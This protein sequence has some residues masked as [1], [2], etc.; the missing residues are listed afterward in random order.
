MR[1]RLVTLVVV[2]VLVGGLLAPTAAAGAVGGADTPTFGQE[3]PDAPDDDAGDETTDSTPEETDAP[4]TAE[5][6]R[7][8]PHDFGEEF[9]SAET[10]ESDKEFNTTGPFALFTTSDPVDAARIEQSAASAT[11]LDGDQAVLV[12][13]DAEAAG[14][15]EQTFFALELF[16]EDGSDT[17][18]DVY[19]SETDVSVEAAELSEFSGLIDQM[20]TDAEAEGYESDVG[21]VESYYEWQNDRVEV[22]EN[23]LVEHA[24]GLF[25]LAIIAAMN[26]LAWVLGLGTI[27]VLAYRR[28]SALGWMLDRIENDAGETARKEREL[29]SRFENQIISADEEPLTELDAVGPQQAAHWKDTYSV[30]SVR[31]LAEL[32]RRG[33]RVRADGGELADSHSGVSEIN[34]DE[35]DDSWLEAIY[36]TNRLSGPREALSHV[37]AALIRMDSK[38]GMG[39]KY[40]DSRAEV[41]ALLAETTPEDYAGGS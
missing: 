33:R 24:A 41:E 19:A 18:A 3:E 16:F 39:H 38:Y 30:T 5:T 9:L 28:E 27:A 13:Y 36:R 7:I 21:G 32:A 31:Q 1:R 11:V 8:T 37:R 10:V 26:P 15:D 40:R 12:E 2:V 20:K 4:A 35:I 23:Y 17:T 6:V 29:V 22:L 25:S 14:A 34:P